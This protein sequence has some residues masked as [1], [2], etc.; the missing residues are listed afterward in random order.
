[1]CVYTLNGC[2]YFFFFSRIVV[3]CTAECE[4]EKGVQKYQNENKQKHT[5]TSE[6]V[7]EFAVVSMVVPF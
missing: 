5:H 2:C 1:M 3:E 4:G 7:H 6:I